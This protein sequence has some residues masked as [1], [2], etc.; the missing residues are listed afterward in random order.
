MIVA[1]IALSL[2]TQQMT[3]EELI[4]EGTM[5]GRAGSAMGLCSALGYSVDKGAGATW[6]QDFSQRVAGAGWDPALAE[7]AIGSGSVAEEVE[8]APPTEAGLNAEQLKNTAATYIAK[9]KARCLRLHDE[10]A[11]LISDLDQGDRNADA[12]LAIMLRGL[13]P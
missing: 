8:M 9:V 4:S 3:Q 11:G 2:L 10:H 5:I 1:A 6:A 13:E 7:R 12:Q